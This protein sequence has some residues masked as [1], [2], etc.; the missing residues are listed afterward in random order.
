MTVE[1]SGEPA[2]SSY[3]TVQIDVTDVNDNPPV[4]ENNGRFTVQIPENTR[5]GST[6]TTLV[7]TDKDEGPNGRVMYEV[8]NTDS[9]TRDTFVVGTMTGD[10]GLIKKLDYE[11]TRRYEMRVVANDMGRPS[12]SATATVIFEVLDS[13]DN[14]PMISLTYLSM[15]SHGEIVENKFLTSRDRNE[16][17]VAVVSVTDDDKTEENNVVT[18]FTTDDRFSLVKYTRSSQ[19]LITDKLFDREE[20]AW[21]NFKLIC[22]D[23][24]QPTLEAIENI[25]IKVLD[26]NDNSP[27][28]EQSVYSVSID[29]NSSPGQVVM[30]VVASDADEGV[31]GTVVYAIEGDDHLTIHGVSGLVSMVIPY[32]REAKDEHRY[33]ITATDKGFPFSLS[34]TSTLIINVND[35]DEAPYFSKNSFHFRILENEPSMT[36]VGKL[37]AIDLDQSDAFKSFT[38]NIERQE[39]NYFEIDDDGTLFSIISLD[40]EV[41]LK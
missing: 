2:L 17:L 33:Q 6:V 23:N 31:N 40:R 21:V 27:A 38:Y 34:S 19:L 13:N 26:I 28:F 10:I 29:E 20:E 3:V 16:S 35:V 15:K 1:D 25:K 5:L 11:T 39:A 32:D 41:S 8:F 30:Q 37:E 7:A 14:P 4:F 22:R 12:L 9:T 18:C 36:V 24:G